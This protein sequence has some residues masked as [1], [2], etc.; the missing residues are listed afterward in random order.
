MWGADVIDAYSSGSRPSGQVN[1]KAVAAMKE[2]GCDLTTHTSKSL[3]DIPDVEY[4]L[5]VTMGCGDAC[6]Y[7]RAKERRDWNIPDPKPLDMS[8]FNKV[9]DLIGLKVIELIEE[10]RQ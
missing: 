9:R 8:E 1:E 7:V 4:D 5:V 10:L 2:A 6:P 3:N